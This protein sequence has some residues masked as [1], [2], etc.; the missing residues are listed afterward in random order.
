MPVGGV[1]G[2]ALPG[3]LRDR[4]NSGADV[5]QHG[6]ADRVA[7]LVA[8]ERADRVVR[9]EARVGAHEDLTCGAGAADAR[10]QL[11]DE[12]LGATLGVGRA[13]A[14]TDVQRLKRV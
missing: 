2:E 14:H 8:L 11:V 7:H 3:R 13:L 1:A 10:D 6:Y 4:C 12:A 5:R 9:P